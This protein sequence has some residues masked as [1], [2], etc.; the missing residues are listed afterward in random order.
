MTVATRFTELVGCTVP[1][2]QAAMGG[3]STPELA[4]AVSNAGGLGMLTGTAND[5]SA[6]I[7]ATVGAVSGRPFGVNFLMPFFE[8]ALLDAVA[9]RVPLV[10]WF[11]GEPDPVLVGV[12]HDAG[13]LAVWQVGS[14]DEALAAA[15]AGCDL[16]VAQG[17]EAGGH[18]RGGIGLVPLLDTILDSVAVPVIAAGGIGT[19]RGVA[20]VLAAGAS[21][22][23]IGT[24][25]VAT[26]ESGVHPTYQQ[27]LVDAGAADTVL[28]EAYS[29]WWPDAPHRVLRSAVEAAEALGDEVVGEVGDGAEPFPI[30]RFAVRPPDRATRGRI[31]A[32]ALY[33]GQSVGAVSAIVPAAEV[34][35]ELGD[36]AEKL[37]NA[38]VQ[39]RQ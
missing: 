28:T 4:A 35:R 13:A 3:A 36:G 24:R 14:R 1:I 31:D 6:D 10:E 2:Q 11:W 8:R 27:A 33:A 25:F 15:A 21:A 38:V 32:M 7:D 16:I 29:V 22:A 39:R 17:V 9:P 5:I 18:V 20:A 23:R 26:V 34:V 19:A 30:P 12:A 37:L